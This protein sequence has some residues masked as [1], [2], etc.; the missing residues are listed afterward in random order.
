MRSETDAATLFSLIVRAP[1]SVE[2]TDALVRGVSRI[3]LS[4]FLESLAP[5][6]G[7]GSADL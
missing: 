6:G 3:V 2:S 4:V 7:A 1:A 5:D